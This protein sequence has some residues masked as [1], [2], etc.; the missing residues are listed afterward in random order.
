M[1]KPD[2]AEIALPEEHPWAKLA[3]SFKDN[4]LFDEVQEHIEAY[5][6]ELDAEEADEPTRHRRGHGLQEDP[7]MQHTIQVALEDT[8]IHDRDDNQLR[9]SMKQGLILLDYLSARISIGRFAEL[10]G[11]GYEQAT[12]WLH[13]RGVATLRKISDPDLEGAIEDNYQTLAKDL[14]IALPET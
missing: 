12:S 10:M 4:P 1:T 6:R 7:R 8:L 11:M 9:Q 13:E 14:G 3:N 2:D 5:R